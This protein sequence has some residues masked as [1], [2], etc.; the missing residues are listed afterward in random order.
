M[1]SSAPNWFV[2]VPGLV[3]DERQPE[4][5]DRRPGPVDDLVDDQPDQGDRAGGGGRSDPLKARRRSG[6]RAGGAIRARR[7][8]ASARTRLPRRGASPSPRHGARAVYHAVTRCSHDFDPGLERR[9]RHSA[10]DDRDAVG[11]GRARGRRPA[12]RYATREVV[13]DIDDLSVT[14]GQTTAFSAVTLDVYKNQITAVI[15]PSGCGKSTFIRCLNRMN[16]LVPGAKV[17][18]KIL[19]HGADIYGGDVDPIEV[20]RRIGMVFQR[21][22]PFPKSIYDNV[23]FA[24]KVLGMRSAHRRARRARA[25][26]GRALG[27]GQGPAEGERARALRRPAA[28]PLHRAALWPSSRT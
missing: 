18:G 16:D 1:K 20:R 13:F 28:A 2:T 22:N 14:Y 4:L 25:A 7:Q 15:G 11:R 24:P 17:G 10:G 27:R 21:P 3:P 12:C 19:Y 26:R 5:A 8:A 9:R 6:R 23:A